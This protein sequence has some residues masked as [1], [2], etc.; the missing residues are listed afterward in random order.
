MLLEDEFTLLTVMLGH[1][2]FTSNPKS[3]EQQSPRC[4]ESEAEGGP[5]P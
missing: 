1:G 2:K 4:T 3:K 5:H